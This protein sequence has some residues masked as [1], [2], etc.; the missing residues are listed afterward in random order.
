MRILVMSASTGG[1]HMRTSAA[2]K[3]YIETSR[4]GD[5]VKIVDTLEYVG[6]LYN[7]T[8]SE[9]YEFMAKNTP[10]LYGTFYNSSNKDTTINNVATKFNKSLAKKLLPLIVEFRPDVIIVV[11]AFA[12]EMA[13]T[14]RTKY[15][16]NIPVICIITDF[17][18]HKMYIQE[19]INSYVVSNDEMIPALREL[20]VPENKIHSLG[21]P[22]DISFYEDYDKKQIMTEMEL[23]P[24]LP[25]LL[26]MAGSFGV[27]DILKIYQNIVEVD[28]D[29]QIVV[30]TGR[31]QKLYDAFEKLLTKN[32]MPP[33]SESDENEFTDEKSKITAALK[34]SAHNIKD[35]IKDTIKENKIVQKLYIGSTGASKPTKLLYF[36]DDI[37]RYMHIADLI[38]T[39]P[40]GLTVS[41]AIASSLPMAIF[42]AFPGQEKENSD[43]L[44]RNNMAVK[45][46]KGSK[47]TETIYEL[48]SQPEKL[49]EMKEACRSKYKAQSAKKVIDLADSLIKEE[50]EKLHET[51]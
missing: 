29:F 47:C 33:E 48:L 5:T 51:L 4:T 21:I 41:E 1:G 28:A 27:T 14:L 9:G 25:T 34:E 20:G 23:D 18:P 35:S 8:V 24:N 12:A 3:K 26:L 6:H 38:V 32:E 40:G 16:M 2:M 44:I 36:V 49:E 15:N 19:G 22:I 13:A 10:T 11:H 37:N 45:L 17:A 7:K 43:Y 46:N 42:S 31:N 39:K 50:E 30:V